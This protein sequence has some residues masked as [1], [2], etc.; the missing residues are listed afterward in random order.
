MT[1]FEAIKTAH[2]GKD[3]PLAV[4]NLGRNKYFY[5]PSVDV[6][7]MQYKKAM[8]MLHKYPYLTKIM[9]KIGYI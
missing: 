2:E 4:R 7:Y 5:D 6:G 3:K 9:K 1:L 8:D